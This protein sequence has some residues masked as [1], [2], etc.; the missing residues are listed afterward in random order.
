MMSERAHYK[1]WGRLK[2]DESLLCLDHIPPQ[3][4]LDW[5][6]AWHCL[7]VLDANRYNIAS[8]AHELG[9]SRAWLYRRLDRWKSLGFV[10]FL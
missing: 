1:K 3:G 9:V 10:S 8:T 4:R 5:V 7:R 6:E 2:V